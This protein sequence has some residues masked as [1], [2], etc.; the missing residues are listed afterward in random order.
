MYWSER[1]L[2]RPLPNPVAG[3]IIV[4]NPNLAS[5]AACYGTS[6]LSGAGPHDLGVVPAHAM[7]PVRVVVV[8]PGF[9]RPGLDDLR[10]GCGPTGDR[11]QILAKGCVRAVGELPARQKSAG[12]L[13]RTRRQPIRPLQRSDP[14]AR[15]HR[16]LGGEH[17]ALQRG[18]AL[19]EADPR[20]QDQQ[21]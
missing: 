14:Q 11:K 5:S 15:T 6:Y 7:T 21:P 2:V 3:R 18:R 8:I 10:G 17:L 20:Q 9:R 13:P 19:A 12:P 4:A 1:L 16:V